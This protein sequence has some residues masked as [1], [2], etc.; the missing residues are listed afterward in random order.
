M[1]RALVECWRTAGT[2]S[3][4]KYLMN[5]GI[6]FSSRSAVSA[7]VLL[8]R[9]DASSTLWL[10]SFMLLLKFGF[11]HYF[12]L[13]GERQ[14]RCGATDFDPTTEE[15]LALFDANMKR[16]DKLQAEQLKEARKNDTRI[17]REN[18]GWT[19]KE[20]YEDARGLP[21]GFPRRH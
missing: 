3:S 8:T 2:T 9:A 1:R 5:S 17:T 14:S 4:F 21:R 12:A 6:S 10:K 15:R 20:L 13:C 11:G 18:R 16:I 19:R 7:T